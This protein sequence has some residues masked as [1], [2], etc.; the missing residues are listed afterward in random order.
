MPASDI[1]LSLPLTR[2]NPWY[3]GQMGVP[4]GW[5]ETGL[6][7]HP[8][9]T[10]F[11]VDPNHALANDGQDGTDPNEPMATIDAAIGKCQDHRGDVIIVGANSAWTYA[12]TAGGYATAVVESVTMDVAGVRLIGVTPG[13]LGVTWNP[14]AADDMLITVTA[15]DC[16][17]EGFCFEGL[18]GCDGIFSLWDGTDN[19]GDSLTIRHCYFDGDID[20]AIQL[21]ESWYTNIHNCYFENCDDYGIYT[22]PLGSGAAYCHVFG[23]RFID[24]GTSAMECDQM[25]DS[26]IAGNYFYNGTAEGGGAS[27]DAFINT[28]GGSGGNLVV[29]NIMSSLL[30]AGNGRYDDTCS[31]DANDAWIHNYL[32]DGV[33]VLPPA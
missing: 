20:T 24:V 23:N 26:V 16:I 7:T 10:V 30:G 5:T 27:P 25:D 11:Y 1:G 12:N 6:R 31:A 18:G 2:L 8:T 32:Q 19:F 3:P 15:I 22:D 28:S 13:T 21:E 14:P 29:H 9:G 33:T 17:I 4:G